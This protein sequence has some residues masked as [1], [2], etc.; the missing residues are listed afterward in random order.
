MA[1]DG[2]IQPPLPRPLYVTS[3]FGYRINPVSHRPELHRGVDFRSR[4]GDVQRAAMS[5]TVWKIYSAA[6]GFTGGNAVYMNHGMVN[7]SSWVTVHM[8]LSRVDVHVGQKI[9]KGQQIGL[10][11]TTGWSTGCHLH[12]ELWRNGTPINAM[13]IIG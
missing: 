10:T 7:G 9:Q 12:F 11:G 6:S 3:P 2:W 1:T 8:H 4:C 13:S 5:G